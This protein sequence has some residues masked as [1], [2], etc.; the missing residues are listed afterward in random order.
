[1]PSKRFLNILTDCT[2]VASHEIRYSIIRHLENKDLASWIEPVVGIS[3]M[4]LVNGA[5]LNR[6][7]AE[8][9]PDESILYTVLNPVQGQPARVV[10]VTE[11]KNLVFV[12][13]NTGVFSWVAKD[14][15]I[16]ALYEV[17]SAQYVPFGGKN[18]YPPVIAKLL[19]GHTA[20]SLGLKKLDIPVEPLDIPTGTIV[21]IDNFGITKLYG[22]L[23]TEGLDVG[24]KLDLTVNGKKLANAIYTPRIMAAQDGEYIVCAGSSLGGLAEIAA[25]RSHLARNLSLKI[26]D[27]IDI[28]YN[29]TSILERV[30]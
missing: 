14:F 25:T 9:C 16:K 30:P 1:M 10:G 24:A 23:K 8:A 6:L 28:L 11:K 13:R 12:G 29:G 7:I 17:S 22:Y 20:E 18:I 4:S 19:E 3:E 21:H 2:D 27:Q 26:G 5:F 15:G